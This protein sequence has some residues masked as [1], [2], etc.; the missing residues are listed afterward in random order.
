MCEF[1]YL[2][3]N[4][5]IYSSKHCGHID[6]PWNYI[7]NS[8][9]LIVRFK[10]NDNGKYGGFIAIWSTTTDPPTYPSPTSAGCGNCNFPFVFGDAMFD[11][12]I[13]IADVDNQ[14]WCGYFVPPI[15]NEGTH[16]ILSSKVSCTES[17]L[18]CPSTP[19]KMLVT[20]PNYP[21]DYPNDV[22]KVTL[23]YIYL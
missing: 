1:D 14:P 15:L 6:Q 12:C 20:S 19:P 13:S 2:F 4:D 21:L 3:L 7:S 17:D 10:S 18:N 8:N 23:L 9:N 11:T 5:G 22:D 16:I